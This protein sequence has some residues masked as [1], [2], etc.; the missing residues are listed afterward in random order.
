MW[1]KCCLA[2]EHLSNAGVSVRIVKT[3][4]LKSKRERMAETMMNISLIII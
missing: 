1:M 3:V 2:T 4:T